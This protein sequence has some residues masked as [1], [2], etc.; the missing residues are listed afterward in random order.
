MFRQLL[1]RYKHSTA[2]FFCN[3]FRDFFNIRLHWL[4]GVCQSPDNLAL[5]ITR[6]GAI[7]QEGRQNLLMSQVLAPRLEFFG[8]LADLLAEP[9]QRLSD[10]CAG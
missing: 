7:A 8:G 4:L 5:A 2:Q 3:C 9:D 10:S 6:H 1:S